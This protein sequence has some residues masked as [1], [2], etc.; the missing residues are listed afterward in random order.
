M[1]KP[2]HLQT[3]FKNILGIYLNKKFNLYYDILVGM[4]KSV[5]GLERCVCLLYLS[6]EHLVY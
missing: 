5:Q 3:H 1:T 6:V 2:Y 4:L